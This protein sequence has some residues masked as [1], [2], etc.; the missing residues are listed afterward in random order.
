MT[1]LAELKSIDVEAV[2]RAIE[3]DTGEPVSG[4]RGRWR[5]PRPGVSRASPRLRK[6]SCARR[7]AK[8]G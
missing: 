1:R 5:M 8:P 7:G 4:T 3:A 2:A 6:C